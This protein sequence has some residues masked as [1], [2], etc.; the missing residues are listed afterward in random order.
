MEACPLYSGL[1]AAQQGEACKGRTVAQQFREEAGGII[2][3]SSIFGGNG[4]EI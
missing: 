3:C 2:F 4:Q 1:I